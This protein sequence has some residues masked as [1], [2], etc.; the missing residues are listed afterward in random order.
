MKVFRWRDEKEVQPSDMEEL[1]LLERA[2]SGLLRAAGERDDL[3]N[4]IVLMGI[5]VAEPK[6]GDTQPETLL[7]KVAYSSLSGRDGPG[8]VEVAAPMVSEKQKAELVPG[9][10]VLIGGY[11]AVR[12][13]RA[14]TLVSSARDPVEIG[15]LISPRPL[16]KQMS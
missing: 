8:A 3:L 13:I 15:E 11:L 5:L 6:V 7:L 4:H 16:E 10:L 2:A 9:R 1:P 14:T 12:G